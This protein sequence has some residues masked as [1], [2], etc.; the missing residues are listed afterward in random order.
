[1]RALRAPIPIGQWILAWRSTWPGGTTVYVQTE[2]TKFMI[3]GKEQWLC[4]C[5]L[6]QNQPYDGTRHEMSGDFPEIRTF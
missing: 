6:S 2:P 4:K 1:M 5:G 3:D